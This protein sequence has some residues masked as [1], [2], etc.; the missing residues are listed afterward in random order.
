MEVKKK[1]ANSVLTTKCHLKYNNRLKVKGGVL[2]CF[3]CV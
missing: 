3:G 1:R 2:N